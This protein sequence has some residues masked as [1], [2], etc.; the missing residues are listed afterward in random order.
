MVIQKYFIY[1]AFVI[2]I[3]CTNILLHG[4]GVLL[5]LL[6]KKNIRRDRRRGRD[7]SQQ[8]LY[9]LNLACAELIWNTNAAIF[10]VS[11]TVNE[12]EMVGNCNDTSFQHYNKTCE[13]TPLMLGS[14]FSLWTGSTF[15]VVCAMAFLTADR[16]LNTCFP[17]TFSVFW[18]RT[19]A[20]ALLTCSWIINVTISITIGSHHF[21]HTVVEI[22]TNLFY[23]FTPSLNSVY[24]ILAL[25]TYV[26]IFVKFEQILR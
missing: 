16:L 13:P 1:I 11:T 2:F 8:R 9:I 25:V 20:I 10:D 24:L 6:E 22:Y 23:Y 18:S 17:L 21:S 4:V 14:A 19:K 12:I 7:R 26:L 5:L 15:N 3:D